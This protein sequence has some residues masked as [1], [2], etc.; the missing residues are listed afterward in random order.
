[1][2]FTQAELERRLAN[3]ISWGTV[4]EADYPNARVKV[5]CGGV[6]TDWLP[7]M[8]QRAGGDRSWWA[9]EVGEQVVLLAPSGELAQ[10][11][12]LLGVF[13]AAHAAPADSPDVD[14]RVYSD[15]AVIEYDRSAHVLKAEIPGNAQVKA[16]GTIDGEAGNL[17]SLKA[18]LIK[19]F[20][21]VIN[22]GHDGGTGT[23]TET[24]N[25]TIEGD[26]TITGTLEVDGNIH[27][28]GTI[29]DD[30]GNTD[31]HSH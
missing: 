13:Q 29:V 9:P 18:P 26:V 4:E 2:S 12:V 7:W 6:L 22:T 1:M 17:I 27:A 20:G 14:R 31:N 19:I 30:S 24:A 21:N 3:I 28:T 5:R 8:T 10:A 15:G 23:V 16:E 25:R 11:V